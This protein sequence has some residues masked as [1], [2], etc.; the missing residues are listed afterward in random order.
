MQAGAASPDSDAQPD[1]QREPDSDTAGQPDLIGE[2][3][4]LLEQGGETARAASETAS[5]LSELAEAEFALARAALP[6]ALLLASAAFGLAVV[7]ALYA[8]AL[9]VAILHHAG[10]S[11]PMA[12]LA[13]T[14]LA[15]I[16]CALLAW[17]ARRTWRLTRFSA[18]RR[19]FTRLLGEKQ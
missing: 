2:A 11:W 19:Q 15:V 4:R 7:A 5:A 6:R 18:T 12:L 10:L 1:G 17:Q 8:L 9:L 3:R 13:A 16:G 14:C